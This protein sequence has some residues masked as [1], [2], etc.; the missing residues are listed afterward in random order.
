MNGRNDFFI[1]VDAGNSTAAFGM[2]KG[3]VLMESFRIP[4]GSLEKAV[5]VER[6]MKLTGGAPAAGCM[7]SSVFPFGDGLMADIC[8]DVSDREPVFFSAEAACGITV[9]YDDPSLLGSDRIASAIACR[10]LFPG[11]DVVIVDAGTAVTFG[12]LLGSGEFVGGLIAPGPGISA[13]CLHD[14][15]AFLPPVEISLPGVLI[16]K[17]TADNIRSGIV[18]GFAGAVEGIIARISGEL[19]VSPRVVLTGGWSGLLAAVSDTDFTIEPDLVLKGLYFV[20]SETR[21]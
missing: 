19:G 20:F 15:T 11:E 16:G 14:K 21:R 10:N 8:R 6:L 13:E 12:V 3:A 1:A 17:N 2:F 4:N 18:Y 5:L 9:C 7:I